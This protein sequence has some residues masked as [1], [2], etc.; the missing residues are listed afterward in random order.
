MFSNLPNAT[1]IRRPTIEFRWPRGGT[2]PA[3]LSFKLRDAL[4]RFTCN[5]LLGRAA[6]IVYDRVRLDL[7]QPIRIDE[8]RHLH[9][10]VDKTNAAKE[11]AAD[12]RPFDETCAA[13]GGEIILI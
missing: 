7:H 2:Q 5:D 9:D 8:A 6:G 10:R 12:T 13:C 1:R 4:P 3:I 11:L